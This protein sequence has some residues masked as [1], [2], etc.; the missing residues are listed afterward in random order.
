MTLTVI[1]KLTRLQECLEDISSRYKKDG[2]L[3]P[4]YRDLM[5]RE[6]LTTVDE[7]FVCGSS[8][9]ELMF[10]ISFATGY[11]LTSTRG[12]FSD[13]RKWME[14]YN[15]HPFMSKHQ[16]LSAGAAIISNEILGED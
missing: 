11:M 9:Q 1:Q 3:Q 16:M 7:F 5:F 14:D 4:G 8:N 15:F 13:L 10:A 6:M 2:P 12:G